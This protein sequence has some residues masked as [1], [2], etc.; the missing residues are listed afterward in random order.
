MKEHIRHFIYL[1]I[2]IV[3]DQ[4]SKYWAKAALSAG[5]AITIIPK[6]LKLQYHENSG[7]V[8]GIL[9]GKAGALSILT[10]FIL[11]ALFFVYLHIP[12]D[13]KYTVLKLVFLLIAA[14][15]VG[16]MIDRIHY[17]Y[18]V[19]FI[20]FELINFPVFNIADSYVTVASALI[21]IL[22]IFYYKDEDL[23]FLEQMFRKKKTGKQDNANR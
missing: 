23:A 16:N 5:N 15:A 21:I 7:A 9:Q 3:I 12:K 11:A 19:D 6:V 8:W 4:A 2:L 1:C 20:Y 10:I 14:G 18:V 13:K 17:N 22:A